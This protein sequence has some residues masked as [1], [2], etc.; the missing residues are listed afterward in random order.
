MS[1]CKVCSV[2]ESVGENDVS[3]IVD[4]IADKS[5]S[6]IA[7]AEILTRNGFPLTEASVRR[8]AKESDSDD[9]D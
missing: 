7:I 1:V 8:H 2:L 5:V 4:S 3:E 9:S 6:R